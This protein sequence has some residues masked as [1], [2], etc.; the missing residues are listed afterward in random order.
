MIET[1]QIYKIRS[2][3]FKNV[4]SISQHIILLRLIC[5]TYLHVVGKKNPER[6]KIVHAW[7]ELRY[8]RNFLFHLNGLNDQF[9]FLY[10]VRLTNG[11]HAI[12][13]LRTSL[14]TNLRHVFVCISMILV[15]DK[16]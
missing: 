9:Y 16:R 12:V 10:K 4:Y 11:M 2:H 5:E 1:R 14:N 3:Q 13:K 7:L 15:Y 8:S 6:N